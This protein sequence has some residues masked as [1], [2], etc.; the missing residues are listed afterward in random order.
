MLDRDLDPDRWIQSPKSSS[1][2]VSHADASRATQLVS[3]GVRINGSA[4]QWASA[5]ILSCKLKRSD[6]GGVTPAISLRA[7]QRLPALFAAPGPVELRRRP[8]RLGQRGRRFRDELGAA[9]P[10]PHVGPP[11]LAVR[12][13]YHALKFN[14]TTGSPTGVRSAIRF[15]TFTAK[16]I[17][18]ND[19]VHKLDVARQCLIILEMFTDLL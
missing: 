14:T 18:G 8:R 19:I 5:G 6:E 1:A 17:I 12:F 15:Y 9:L 2:D 16:S 7:R 13:A 3:I 10:P 11:H 4:G